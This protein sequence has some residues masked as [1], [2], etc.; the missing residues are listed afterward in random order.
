M[1]IKPRGRSS[2]SGDTSRKR[3]GVI[4]QELEQNHPEFVITNN[5]TGMKAVSYVDMLVAKVAELEKRINQLENGG[6]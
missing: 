4:A 2:G 6:A 5:E 1:L 3:V